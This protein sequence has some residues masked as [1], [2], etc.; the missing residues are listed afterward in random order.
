MTVFKGLS[1]PLRQ[2]LPFVD[3]HHFS[4]LNMTENN[5]AGLLLTNLGSPN[6]TEVGDIRKY[7]TAFL[8]D[9]RVIDYPYLFRALL[10]KGI[11]A[12]RR[13]PES[14]KAYKKV[15]LPEGSPLIVYAERLKERV[16]SKAPFPV[17]LSMRYG[18]PSTE[19]AFEELLVKQPGLEE[20]VVLPLYPQ[21][22][23]SSF[24]TA[25]E[26]V[27]RVH[28]KGN[29]PFRL[30]FLAPFYNQ[31]DYIAA[32]AARIRP[33]LEET[34]DKI[35]FTYHGLPERHM[36]KDDA[37][38]AAG[39]ADFC[40]PPVNYQQQAYE[41]TRLTAA[42]LNIPQ[43]RYETAFQSRLAAAKEW[44]KPYTAVRLEALPGEGVKRLLVVS[45]AFI[46]D[47]LETIE[48]IGM[49]G[50]E[51]FEKAGGEQLTLIPCLNDQEQFA[52]AIVKWAT[53]GQ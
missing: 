27:K 12:P 43:E 22:T 48:E 16:Q 13:A 50:K 45:P 32:L 11:V 20:V 33:F 14:A 53:Q 5:H 26:E 42:Y 25:V 2:L 52:E 19:K 49:T 4:L 17:A 10:V 24:D 46:N 15:W 31:A 44:L 40:L 39:K 35:L 3:G 6:S 36:G 34:Y 21:Y 18:Q 41:T 7:L 38:I 8:M 9:R 47:C 23:M 30:R 37:R 51:A 28:R 1:V 29:Y